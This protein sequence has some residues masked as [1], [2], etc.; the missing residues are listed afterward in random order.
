M[1]IIKY[2]N[3][4]KKKI[5]NLLNFPKN[6]MIIYHRNIYKHKIVMFKKVNKKWYLINRINL[7]NKIKIKE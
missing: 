6:N 5:I 2:R 3:I 7:I 1:K 4:N